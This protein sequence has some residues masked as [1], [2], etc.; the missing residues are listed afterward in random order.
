[1]KPK[2]LRKIAVP[3]KGPM[4]IIGRDVKGLRLGYDCRHTLFRWKLERITITGCVGNALTIARFESEREA[5]EAHRYLLEFE[6]G[7]E[8]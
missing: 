3:R 1:M 2:T 7:V 6:L 5:E 4:R 8:L